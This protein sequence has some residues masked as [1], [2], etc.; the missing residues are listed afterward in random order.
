[1]PCSPQLE[2]RSRIVHEPLSAESE[3]I[4]TAA[5]EQWHISSS[6]IPEITIIKVSNNGNNNHFEFNALVLLNRTHQS[7]WGKHHKLKGL[8]KS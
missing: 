7:L 2:T 1:M 3:T 5:D 6:S 8:P 4:P